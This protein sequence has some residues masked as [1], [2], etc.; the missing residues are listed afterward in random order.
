[1]L[2]PETMYVPGSMPPPVSTIPI[3][4]L[5]ALDVKVVP[6]IGLNGSNQVVVGPREYMVVGFDLLSDHETMNLWYSKDFDEIRM[7]AN[8]NYGCT[9]ATFGTTKYFATN[10]L[11]SI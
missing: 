3:A 9:I 2:A 8:Y 1:M 7:R 5:P 4:G 10:G 6:T 11:G